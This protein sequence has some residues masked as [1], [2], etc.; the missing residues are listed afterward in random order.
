[1][2]T[3]VNIPHGARGVPTRNS[4]RRFSYA[5]RRSPFWRVTP[6][7]FLSVGLVFGARKLVRLGGIQQIHREGRAEALTVWPYIVVGLPGWG[8]VEF[9]G[10]PLLPPAVGAGVDHGG[11]ETVG[12][13]LF[14]QHFCRS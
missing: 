8:R 14:E 9:V 3:H 4:T 1:M 7:K 5:T 2:I 11:E 13:P 10:H 6:P 12:E